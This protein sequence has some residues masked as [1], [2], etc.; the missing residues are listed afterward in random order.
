MTRVAG[1]VINL[2]VLIITVYIGAEAVAISIANSSTGPWC[3]GAPAI[4]TVNIIDSSGVAVVAGAAGK[5]GH[6]GVR[7]TIHRAQFI[8]AN[9]YPGALRAGGAPEALADRHFGALIQAG[10]G[11]GWHEVFGLA[12]PGIGKLGVRPEAMR[13]ETGVGRLHFLESIFAVD[14]L[15]TGGAEITI[16]VENDIRREVAADVLICL[17]KVENVVFEL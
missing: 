6:F 9:I 12:F 13:L 14:L 7:I 2:G 1:P 16:V 3:A 17:R 8:N 11:G 15:R 4:V 10:A 5:A